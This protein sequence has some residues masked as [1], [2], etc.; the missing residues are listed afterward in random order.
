MAGGR[1][2]ER[3]PVCP[4]GHKKWVQGHLGG[5]SLFAF[6]D[7]NYFAHQRT[8]LGYPSAACEATVVGRSVTP[9]PCHW[10]PQM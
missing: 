7:A 4:E 10:E 2:R 8:G 1:D 3:R 9:K 6:W 5:V